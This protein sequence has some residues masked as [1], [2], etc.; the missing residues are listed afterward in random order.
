MTYTNSLDPDQAHSGGIPERTVEK[1]EKSAEDKMDEK[2]PS[3]QRV[4]FTYCRVNLSLIVG[5]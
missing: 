5:D 3:M 2:L 4:K 1:K